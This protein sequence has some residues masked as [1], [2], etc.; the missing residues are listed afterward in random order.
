MKAKE[1]II[2]GKFGKDISLD[3]SFPEGKEKS[4]IVV[5]MHGFK[6]FKDWGAWHLVSEFFVQ[7]GYAFCKFNFSHGGVNH[8]SPDD[9]SDLEA[10]SGNNF[11]I[12]L[13]DTTIVLDW[14]EQQ[15]NIMDKEIYLI[16]HSRAGGIAL[17]TAKEQERVKKVIT[18]GA[19]SDYHRYIGAWKID[20][21]ATNG[22]IPF[23]NSRTK[24][25]FNIDY[26]F[27]EVLS[28]NESFF[29]LKQVCSVLK[30]PIMVVHAKDD[31][32]VSF[33]QAEELVNWTK[34]SKLF[35]TETG[36]HTFDTFHPYD[37]NELPAIMN[38]VCHEV[39]KFIQE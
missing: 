35:L 30:Q 29:D 27:Y 14:L 11:F 26:Q 2:E 5:F 28:A 6:G 7:R 39:L 36:G 32:A 13:S 38:E 33:D 1:Y 8:S 10:F 17:I 22:F 23:V 25:V 15:E 31:A 12:E 19:V 34:D 37:E 24:Q 18:W 4:P 3:L 16:G 20:E 9:L 21:W